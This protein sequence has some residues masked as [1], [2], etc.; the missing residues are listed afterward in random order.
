[1]KHKNHEVLIAIAEGKDVEYRRIG[2]TEWTT[3]GEPDRNVPNPVTD[4]EFVYWRIKHKPVKKLEHGLPSPMEK[5]PEIGDVYWSIGLDEVVDLKYY[6]DDVDRSIIKRRL[7][8]ATKEEAERVLRI[9]VE[10][11]GGEYD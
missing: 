10:M 7:A 2:L 6:H 3:L 1:M 5:A 4:I 9:L 8:W 11:L